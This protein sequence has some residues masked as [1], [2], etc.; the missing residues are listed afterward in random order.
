MNQFSVLFLP[1]ES[2]IFVQFTDLAPEKIAQIV[3][4]SEAMSSESHI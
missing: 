1:N 4:D 3:K 2:Y